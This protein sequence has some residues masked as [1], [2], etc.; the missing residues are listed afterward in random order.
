MVCEGTVIG[1][2]LGNL[3]H[4]C[5]G[6]KHSLR[7][8]LSL[9]HRALDPVSDALSLST[10]DDLSL[11]VKGMACHRV[12]QAQGRRLRELKIAPPIDGRTGHIGVAV[13]A[14]AAVLVA[15]E[16]M[17]ASSSEPSGL[18]SQLTICLREVQA[19]LVSWRVGDAADF[20]TIHSVNAEMRAIERARAG[21]ARA[22]FKA[23]MVG[24]S[25]SEAMRLQLLFYR[26]A[27][28]PRGQ[29][30]AR[31]T[32]SDLLKRIASGE[33][34]DFA[35][36][37]EVFTLP[38]P[39]VL[40]LSA[41]SS[42]K[43]ERKL[44]EA[45]NKSA[46]GGAE[47]DAAETSS[48]SDATSLSGSSWGSFASSVEIGCFRPLISADPGELTHSMHPLLHPDVIS[49][50]ANQAMGRPEIDLGDIPLFL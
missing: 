12:L 24:M 43:D 26:R 30:I 39:G 22:C 16:C 36:P 27:A 18:A 6:S 19:A 32:Q 14:C 21:V 45:A 28:W 48:A 3:V 35:H 33:L 38:T 9:M 40:P 49:D 4:H 11:L 37:V 50:S 13:G 47:R 7:V 25:E 46:V 44:D 41:V 23:E 31:D 29:Q 8:V 20:D 15:F 34:V 17:S 10:G 2:A 42:V 1:C 5:R